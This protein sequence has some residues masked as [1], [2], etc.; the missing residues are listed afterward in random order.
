MLATGVLAA[1]LAAPV[2]ADDAAATDEGST[3]AKGSTAGTGSTDGGDARGSSGTTVPVTTDEGGRRL[4]VDE[5]PAIDVVGHRE[6]GLRE[7]DLVGENEQPRWTAHRR[8][9]TTRVYVIPAWQ[10]DTEY[11][12]RTKVER[13]GSVEFEHRQ[14]IEI[15][16][17]YRFQFDFY[18]IETHEKDSGDLLL[19]QA[20]ELRYAFAKWGRLP[21]NPTTYF[22]WIHTEGHNPESFELKILFGDE[23]APRWHWGANFIWEQELGGARETVAEWTPAVSYTIIDEVLSLG[24]EGKLEA[25]SEEPHRDHY[26]EN[27][28]LGPS[29]Q[30][31]PFKRLHVDFAPLFGL[32]ENSR[33]ADMYL[34]AGWEF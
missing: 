20:F 2:R 23:F 3:G 10:V 24:I 21:G 15:G 1:L 5:M 17:P 26:T 7:E 30:W 18:Q 14:E 29:V 28:R 33:E 31:R 8:F 25:A 9:P 27:V 6:S 34:I 16:L 19:S 22:E 12:L 4:R 13:D 11:W 32:T